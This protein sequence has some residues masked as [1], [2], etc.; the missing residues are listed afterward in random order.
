MARRSADP[1]IGYGA[2]SDDL[3]VMCVDREGQADDVVVPA[4]ELQSI[5][6]AP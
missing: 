6:A 1:G 3:A 4:G 2:T 5:A